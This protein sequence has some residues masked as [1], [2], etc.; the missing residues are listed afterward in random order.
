M[1]LPRRR[2]SEEGMILVNVLL[3]VAIASG[4]VM[5]MISAEDIALQR[6][7]RMRD[8]A[9][10]QA[11]AHGGEA[12]AIVALRR[13][14]LLASESDHGA[15]PWAAIAERNRPIEGG[16][17]DL[18]ITDAQSRFNVNILMKG[19][20]A[21][22]ELLGRIATV[23]DLPQELAWRATELVRLKGPIAD[24]HP[25]RFAGLDPWAHARLTALITALPYDTPVNVNSASEELLAVMLGNPDAAR[26]LVARRRRQGSLTIDDFAAVHAPLPRSAGFTSNL[27]W[28]RTRVRIGDSNQQL[29][30]LIAR[31]RDEAGRMI[32]APIARWR[33]TEL[34]DQ[35][36]PL[37]L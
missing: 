3:F 21:D 9:R 31:R 5:L 2:P 27:F 1:S 24:L 33:G 22:V 15:E 32:V 34:P 16:S 35:A 6:A 26:D 18:V 30:S 11:I 4:I 36:P 29:T 28:V 14:A 19:N 10:A 17:F 23:L 7:Q 20:A 8:A 13:D 37:P 12:S 25:L